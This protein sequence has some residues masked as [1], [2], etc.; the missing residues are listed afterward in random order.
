MR[1]ID[2]LSRIGQVAHTIS[3]VENTAWKALCEHAR[4]PLSGARPAESPP[5]GAIPVYATQTVHVQYIDVEELQRLAEDHDAQVH[6]AVRSGDLVH[7]SAPLAW[8]KRHS[9]ATD[10]DS[11]SSARL[12]KV[13]S[14]V[15]DAF[16][17]GPERTIEQDAGYGLIVLAEIALRA[18]SPAMNDPG[19]AIAVLGSQTRLLIRTLAITPDPDATVCDRVT[20]RP[21]PLAP[22]LTIAY[23]PI[24]RCSLAHFDVLYQLVRHL[25]ALVQNAPADVALEARAVVQRALERA[26]RAGVDEVDLKQWRAEADRLGLSVAQ[27]RG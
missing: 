6:L 11:D 17:V 19:T 15:R 25:E 7:P 18:L 4:N 22:L 12:D 27:R 14:S 10:S 2:V 9:A 5:E 3:I 8:V 21:A 1:Y 24:A 16:V 20:A 26:E 23:E 13:A